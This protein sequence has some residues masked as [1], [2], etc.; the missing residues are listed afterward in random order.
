MAKAKKEVVLSAKDL[1]N[2]TAEQS[3]KVTLD[4]NLEDSSVA[5]QR[6]IEDKKQELRKLELEEDS[7]VREFVR[8][9][10]PNTLLDQGRGAAIKED[11]A[12]L[13]RIQKER[14]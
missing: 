3:N 6:A 5:L 10:D 1:M 8:T 2:Q 9:Q 7:N 13:V 4:R 14:F 12:C 11:L